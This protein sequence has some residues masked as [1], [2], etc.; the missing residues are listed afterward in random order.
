MLHLAVGVGGTFTDICLFDDEEGSTRV[1]KVSSTKDPVDAVLE[2][3]GE[4]GTLEL[5]R[6]HGVILDWGTGDLLPKSAEGY[7]AMLKRRVVPHWSN[8]KARSRPYGQ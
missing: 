2:G 1:G 3:I 8:T 4:V 5:M 6:R 7:Q